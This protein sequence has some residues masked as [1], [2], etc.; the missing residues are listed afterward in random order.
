ME[1]LLPYK[2]MKNV[3]EKTKIYNNGNATKKFV[4]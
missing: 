4:I 3:Y 1:M 2:S